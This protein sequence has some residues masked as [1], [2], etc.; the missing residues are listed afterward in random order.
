MISLKCL[1]N[2]LCLIVCAIATA[3]PCHLAAQDS[4]YSSFLQKVIDESQPKIAK[5]YG[6]GAGKVE[7][8]ATG[9]IV[10]DDG[11]ILTTQGVFLDGRQVKVGFARY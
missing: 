4:V 3:L 9:I 11:K 5:I 1:W 10:S 7:G 8:F 2:L 6:A